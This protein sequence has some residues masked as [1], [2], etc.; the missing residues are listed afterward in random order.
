MGDW[1]R[2]AAERVA[3]NEG[4]WDAL[5]KIGD[6]PSEVPSCEAC[7]ES[8]LLTEHKDVFSLLTAAEFLAKCC[9]QMPRTSP[10]DPDEPMSDANDDGET[11]LDDDVWR[12]T[13]REPGILRGLEVALELAQRGGIRDSAT[14][15]A[16]LVR[17]AL[18]TGVLGHD[19][20]HTEEQIRE[21]FGN[22]VAN[23]VGCL[24]GL[25]PGDDLNI[26]HEV[27]TE[28]E[29]NLPYKAKLILLAEHLWGLRDLQVNGL[30]TEVEA[31]T[32]RGCVSRAR[33]TRRVL[34]GTHA[35]LEAS[36][37][38][39]F[40]GQVRLASGEL[41]PVLSNFDELSMAA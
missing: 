4:G 33:E 35:D 21:R 24:M 28:R 2:S 32:F 19:R 5:T 15:R 38:E 18:L 26:E 27:D 39:V 14:L 13:R 41:V 20:E 1:E 34:A 3:S 25:P 10:E 8:E 16:A 30:R 6:L 40:N 22:Q 7:A 17:G 11:G 31:Q 9:C 36:L 37:D 29:K 23:I 12:R